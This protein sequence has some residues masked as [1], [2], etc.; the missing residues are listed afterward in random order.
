MTVLILGGVRSVTVVLGNLPL[1]LGVKPLHLRPP[2]LCFYIP[3]V[4]MTFN[5]TESTV[6]GAIGP[7]VGMFTVP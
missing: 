5:R 6:R 1:R 3:V 2:V 4:L 7:V